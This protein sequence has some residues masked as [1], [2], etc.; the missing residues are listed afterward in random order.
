MFG[1][2]DLNDHG[3][4]VFDIEL[5]V[6]EIFECVSESFDFLLQFWPGCIVF[7]LAFD[8]HVAHSL[9]LERGH[10]GIGVEF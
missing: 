7:F 4:I 3:C 5:Q 10:A 6:V 1:D 2:M 9:L 8:G